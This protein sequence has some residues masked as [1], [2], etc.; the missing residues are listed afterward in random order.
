VDGK[1]LRI[2]ETLVLQDPAGNELAVIHK[3]VLSL[4]DTMTVERDGET[5]V[6]VRKKLFTPFHDTYRAE[7][8]SGGEL[9]VRGS[10]TDRE[11]DIEYDGERL[12]R[13]SRKWFS[14]RDTYALDV[15]RDDADVAMLIAVAVCVDRLHEH[16][17]DERERG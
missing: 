9:E 12:A 7:L 13:V 14:L 10:I 11:Y 3:K 16:E 8:A 5:L 4:R 2:R 15:E 17:R 6:S 1:V